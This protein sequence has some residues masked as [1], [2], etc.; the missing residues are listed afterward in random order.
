MKSWAFLAK[1]K[2]FY[3]YEIQIKFSWLLAL[4]V[5]LLDFLGI[6]KWKLSRKYGLENGRRLT[7]VD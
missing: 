3:C 2:L 7:L 4:F 5:T 1:R 6:L